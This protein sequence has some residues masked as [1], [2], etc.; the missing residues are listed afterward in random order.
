MKEQFSIGCMELN[1]KEK[2]GLQKIA[3][4]MVIELRWLDY[5]ERLTEMVITRLE[6][7]DLYK[8]KAGETLQPVFETLFECQEW[9][10]PEW[11]C[12]SNVWNRLD[13]DDVKTLNFN[14]NHAVDINGMLCEINKYMY[15]NEIERNHILYSVKGLADKNITPIKTIEENLNVI[16]Q[17][18]DNT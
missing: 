7:D 8:I 18:G 2:E 13:V 15:N 16:L 4:K 6:M 9:F 10:W 12:L 1:G 14:L 17:K 5:E 11:T 3:I